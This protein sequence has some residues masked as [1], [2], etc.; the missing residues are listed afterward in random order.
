MRLVLRGCCVI[1]VVKFLFVVPCDCCWR[2]FSVVLG[3]LCVGL[4]WSGV[5]RILVICVGWWFYVV[6]GYRCLGIWVL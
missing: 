5:S 4:R 3:W 2:E 1:S 6:C